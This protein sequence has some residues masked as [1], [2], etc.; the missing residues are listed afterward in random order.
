MARHCLC[1]HLTSRRKVLLARRCFRYWTETVPQGQTG[2]V[3]WLMSPSTLESSPS[4]HMAWV[5]LSGRPALKERETRHMK[6]KGSQDKVLIKPQSLIL[7]LYL[8]KTK[9]PI[10]C[11][12]WIMLQSK[13]SGQSVPVGNCRCSKAEVSSWVQLWGYLRSI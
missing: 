8:I 5:H 10:L 13:L 6:E 4:A 3:P 12:S 9:K 1:S 11:F 2:H 7:Q